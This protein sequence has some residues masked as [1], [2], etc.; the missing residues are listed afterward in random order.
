MNWMS[1]EKYDDWF[2]EAFDEAFDR[3]AS[4]SSLPTDDESK[5]QSWQQVKLQVEK[6]N[7]RKQR[8]R[9]FQLAGIIA[10]SMAFGAFVF[11]QPTV[12]QAVSPIYQQIVDWGNGITG[13]IFGKKE[14]VDPS[15]AL[16]APPPDISRA[17]DNADQVPPAELVETEDV[18]F[19]D[20]DESLIESQ[21]RVL[22]KIPEVGYIPPG[23]EFYEATGIAES[24]NAP[25]LDLHLHYKNADEKLFYIDL[26]DM[27]AERS[28]GLG[29]KVTETLKL[30]SGA[31]AYLTETNLRF[32]HDNDK[33]LVNISGLF[34]RE[35]FIKIANSI[36]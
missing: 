23:F 7:N 33:I 32:L 8:R 25:I 26:I 30:K 27:T 13:Q 21:K 5:R 29:G 31:V 11:S 2:D 24:E 19:T 20:S 3:A 16:T 18:P 1:N 14:P 35:E 12:T 34:S 9:R 17:P 10:A 4:R 28:I 36:H 22:F 15:K 6:L